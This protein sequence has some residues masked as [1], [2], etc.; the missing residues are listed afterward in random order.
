[1]SKNRSLNHRNIQFYRRA[2]LLSTI[3]L[4]Y[5]KNNQFKGLLNGTIKRISRALFDHYLNRMTKERSVYIYDVSK[6]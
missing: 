3:G 5:G 2:F 1:T 4:F 6:S